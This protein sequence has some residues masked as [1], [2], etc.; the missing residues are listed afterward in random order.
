MC[1]P[2]AECDDSNGQHMSLSVQWQPF[3]D[4]ST[5]ALYEALSLR[6]AVFI[7]EQNCVFL[8]ADG[9]DVSAIHGLG[10]DESGALVAVARILPPGSKHPL[11]S[12]GRL[13]VAR[14]LRRFGH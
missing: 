12:I 1:E 11:P 10:R 2:P 3:A 6:Q 7:V 9:H 14:H 13:A 8:D 5:P 4:L